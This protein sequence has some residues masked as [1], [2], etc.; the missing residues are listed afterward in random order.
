MKITNRVFA[1]TIKVGDVLIVPFVDDGG[2][3]KVTLH[4]VTDI[5]VREDKS[6]R[7]ST[8]YAYGRAKK[9]HGTSHFTF[10]HYEFVTKL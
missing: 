7:V 5:R 8:E 1:Y 10:D 6:I 4:T 3:A 2:E 9:L